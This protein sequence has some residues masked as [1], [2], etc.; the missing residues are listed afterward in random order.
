MKK[1]IVGILMAVVICMTIPAVAFAAGE[2]QITNTVIET[3]ESGGAITPRAVG[4]TSSI[5]KV[6]TTSVRITGTTVEPTSARVIVQLQ[7]YKNGSWQNY[8]SSVSNSG[9]GRITATK[10]VTIDRGYKYRTKSVHN[11]GTASYSNSLSM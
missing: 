8:G 5:S 6:S 1:K 11:G 10:V 2:T 7:V 9:R 3:Q 4:G